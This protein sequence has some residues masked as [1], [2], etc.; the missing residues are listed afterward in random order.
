MER[1]LLTP[2]VEK[3]ILI[4]EFLFYAEQNYD[5]YNSA[6]FHLINPLAV[7]AVN[8]DFW[9]LYHGTFA[10]KS[11]ARPFIDPNRSS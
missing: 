4:E 11:F 7:I 10:L 2:G 1:E 8:L 3:I 9:F 6:K 5:S